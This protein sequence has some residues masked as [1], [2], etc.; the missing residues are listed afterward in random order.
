MIVVTFGILQFAICWRIIRFPSILV[1]FIK[2]IVCS[3]LDGFVARYLA[4]QSRHE[5]SHEPVR[6]NRIFRI[7][8]G[9]P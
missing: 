7:C 5:V 1:E 6:Q 4:D 2:T 9:W 8:H 3:V